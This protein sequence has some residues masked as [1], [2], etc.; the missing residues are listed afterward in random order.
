[1]HR[2]L[3]G[4]NFVWWH[5]SKIEE[6]DFKVLEDEFKFHPLDFDDL[7]E[8]VEL[9]KIDIYKHY[10]FLVL[11]IPALNGVGLRVVK[12]NLAIFVG[13]DYVVTITRDEIEA[14]DRYFARAS[15][16][17]GLRKEVMS[18]STGFF[19]YKLL[20]YAFR[21]AKVVLRELA[22]ETQEVE[23][24]VYDEHTKVT[25]TRLGSL[26]RNVLFLRHIMDPQRLVID[27]I[28]NAHKT[29]LSDDLNIYFEDIKDTL[30]E[31]S[32]VGENL[33]NIVEGLFD[34][35]EAFLSHRTNS[36]IR[37]LTV[38]S[39]ILMPPTL[40][41]GYFGMNVN[42]IPFVEDIAIVSLIIVISMIA[43]WLFIQRI[44]RR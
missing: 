44:D 36:I 4:K 39:V 19:L 1:M 26:R 15:R 6:A 11:N 13:K 25:T 37:I 5:F 41:T 12:S 34:V 8:E 3:K 33:K 16:S 10:I 17:N 38:I 35:N 30:N 31:V 18:K 22:R 23:L 21:D 29:F 14:V 43:F 24:L 32:I 2:S 42:N 28:I 7:R 9:P 27:H 40:I 20:D